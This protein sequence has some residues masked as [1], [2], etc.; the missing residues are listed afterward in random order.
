MACRKY[1][2]GTRQL[3]PSNMPAA[4]LHTSASLALPTCLPPPLVT[5]SVCL[6]CRCTHT[7]THIHSLWLAHAFNCCCC[8]VICWQF[9]GGGILVIGN[10]SNH[11]AKHNF[12]CCVV[13]A[14]AKERKQHG[15]SCKLNILIKN[16]CNSPSKHLPACRLKC[17]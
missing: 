1:D 12:S 3:C 16:N 10:A 11:N 9:T 13:Q 5:L 14:A 4:Y 7:H 2:K 6:S 8:S 15:T 17:S